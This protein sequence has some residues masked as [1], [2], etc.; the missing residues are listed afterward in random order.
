LLLASVV[1]ALVHGHDHPASGIASSPHGD[2]TQVQP[3]LVRYVNP[4]VG[5]DAGQP[6]F[7]L[8]GSSGNT[9]PGAVVPFGMVQWSPDT[10]PSR[11]SRHGHARG[12][13]YAYG[14]TVIRGF[15]LTHLS[16]TGCSIYQ[17]VP[18]LPMLGPVVASPATVAGRT[19]YTATF[20]HAREQAEPGYYGVRLHSGITVALSATRRTGFAVFTYPPTQTATLLINT[21][22]S[23][24][25]TSAALVTITA[26][27]EVTGW[28]SSGGFCGT[29][30]PYTIYYVAQ[31]NRPFR[32]Y[33]TWS[34]ATM[35]PGS[36]RSRGRQCGA[37]VSFDTMH[38]PAVQVK[39]GVSFVS[40]ANARANLA[41][42]NPGWDSHRVRAA[43]SATWNRMLNRVA[44][45]GGTLAQKRTFY[46]ALYHAL[47]FPSTFSDANGQY[48][49]FDDRVHTAMYRDAHGATQSYVQYAN[50]SGWDI[51]RSEVPLLALLAPHEMGDM[52]QS[53]VADAQ[54]S[55]WLPKWSVANRHTDV[56]VGDPADLIIA[57]AYAFGATHFDTRAALRAMLTGA[58]RTQPRSAKGYVER[59]GLEE[60]LAR[61]YIPFE[62]ERLRGTPAWVWGSA[63][64]T[65]E[66]AAADFAIAQ[67][68]GTLGDKA[69]RATYL[70]RAQNWR[71]LYDPASGYIEPRQAN[72]RFS[73]PYDPTS[74]AGFVEGNGAQYTWMVPYDLRGLVDAMGGPARAAN[75]LDALFRRLNAGPN[76]PSAFLGNEPSAGTPW[77]YDFLG[78]PWR[79]QDVVR[80]AIL[81]LYN[82]SPGGCPGND[83]LG[84][85][86]A[87]YVFAAIG[88]YPAVPGVG[89]LA[90]GS[91]LFPRITLHLAHGDLRVVAPNASDTTLYVQRL[92]VDGRP[93]QRTWLPV[94]LLADGGSLRF[95][96]G[97][98]PN[99]SWG[100][101]RVSAL[102]SLEG[103]PVSAAMRSTAS[104]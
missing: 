72:G 60:Y 78:R 43:A 91:P 32:R 67:F 20:S 35:M 68:A 15:S 6:D 87:W 29:S 38:H 84:Q 48:M 56:M 82:A 33:G 104:R 101:D 80:Q 39:V 47:L 53:L 97:T 59:P 52:V 49:G 75:R 10:S 26:A 103:V 27:H 30:S 86:S 98:K 7:G 65:L 95:D 46:T 94:G 41:Q 69:T 55:G 64:T 36:T 22:G 73:V 54:Q 2:G 79:T 57:G 9:F 23:A 34:G 4:F 16:G 50:F 77:A 81:H 11:S 8:I 12:S 5:T 13:T 14:D 31:F 45:E 93:Y 25:G 37:Y 89:D 51:Y 28:A 83:D 90:I 100:T 96:L 61:D 63:A 19:P 102:P 44:I 62:R 24:N 71:M 70:H 76:A 92:V 3:A 40:I 88:L 1:G 58:T 66:Y 99:T 21:G 74:S 85:M 42:E 17:D 18:F